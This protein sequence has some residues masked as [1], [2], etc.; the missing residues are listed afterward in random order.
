MSAKHDDL[1][2]SVPDT[3]P[4]AL[5]LIDLINDLEFEGGERMLSHLLRVAP[6]IAA[7]KAKARKRHVPVIY[8]NDNFGRWRSD[9]RQAVAHCL[10]DGV[11]GR[12]VV[13]LLKPVPEDYFVLKVRHSA[14]FST[15][16][17]R[18]LRDL[19]AKR[20]VIIG[21]SGDMCV[22]LTAADAYMRDLELYVPRD[23]VASISAAEN[24][25]AL[26]YMERVFKAD[27]RPSSKLDF[28]KLRRR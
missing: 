8:A 12:Q 1:H 20:I 25:K 13:E 5:V 14:F 23:C 18:L 17:E 11:R 28:S 27:T 3:S 26:R 15:A 21:V 6:R 7:L 9:F 4:V 10:Q 19:K 22:L 16:L 2:G 24:R